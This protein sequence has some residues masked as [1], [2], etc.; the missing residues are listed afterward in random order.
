MGNHQAG[1]AMGLTA[2][3]LLSTRTNQT[4]IELLDI[5]C[6]PYKGCDAEFESENGDAFGNYTDPDA[7]IGALIMEAFG[8]DR[9]WKAEFEATENLD[10]FYEVWWGEYSRTEEDWR[11][12][13]DGPY[14]KFRKRYEFC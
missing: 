12:S 4:A 11:G 5:I 10:D 7:P 14:G 1:R 2:K 6:T 3:S 13:W 9:D 8:G